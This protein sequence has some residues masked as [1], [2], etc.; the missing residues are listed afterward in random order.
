MSGYEA[1]YDKYPFLKGGVDAAKPVTVSPLWS[2]TGIV[3]M[4]VPMWA[5]SNVNTDVPEYTLPHTVYHELAH[6]RQFSREDECNFI[7]YVTCLAADSHEFRYSGRMFALSLLMTEL[8]YASPEE[9][10]LF[11]KTLDEGIVNDIRAKNSY[12]K[13]HEGIVER[14]SSAVN[15]AFITS[16][17]VASG[18][19]SYSESVK[20][21]MADII[22]EMSKN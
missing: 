4:Y 17:G 6:S 11:V 7:S 20:L 15:N 14:L 18:T 22:K 8:Y 2:Y 16:Q 3:G 1:L 9:Y 5:E 19:R 21:I 12:W 13:E 10:S